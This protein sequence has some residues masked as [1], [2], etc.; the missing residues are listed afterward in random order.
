[1]DMVIK[2]DGRKEV[3]IPEK[4]VVSATKTGASPDIARGIARD[5]GTGAKDG[6]TT[7]E[8]RKNVL[9]EL[10]AKNPEWERNWMVF[11][12]AVKE[13]GLI[14]VCGQK[15]GEKVCLTDGRQK[16]M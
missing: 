10:K 16:L 6:I 15:D 7:R 4:I 1:M 14:P 12:T 11:D 3:F 13:A 9:Q 2:R 5:I 8:I